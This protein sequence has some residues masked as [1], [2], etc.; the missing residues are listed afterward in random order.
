MTTNPLTSV[1]ICALRRKL[2]MNMIEFGNL[3]SVGEVVV[4]NWERGKRRP[5]PDK[6]QRLRELQQGKLTP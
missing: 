4:D 2:R 3:F 1:E 6:M 5:T